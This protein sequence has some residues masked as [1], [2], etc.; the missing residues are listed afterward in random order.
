M[1]LFLASSFNTN[2]PKPPRP[3]YP[4]SQRPNRMIVRPPPDLPHQRLS[5]YQDASYVDQSRPYPRVRPPPPPL[6]PNPSAG[7]QGR[8]IPYQTSYGLGRQQNK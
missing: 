2:N 1:D 6:M 7:Y 8:N 3:T 5:Q 4:P